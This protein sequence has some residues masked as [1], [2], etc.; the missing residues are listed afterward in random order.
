MMRTETLPLLDVLDVLLGRKV[1]PTLHEDNETALGVIKTGKTHTMR[2]LWRTHEVDIAWLNDLH[3]AGVFTAQKC[4]SGDMRADMFTKAFTEPPRW[5][6]ACKLIG[7]WF[8]G[9]DGSLVIGA[10]TPE[11][12]VVATPAAQRDPEGIEAE[13]EYLSNA[14]REEFP[15]GEPIHVLTHDDGYEGHE[16]DWKEKAIRAASQ[17]QSCQK[18]KRN[19]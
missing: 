15:L 5:H 2:H 4:P 1:I 13:T 11:D 8:P 10:D 19:P 18:S 14:E 12:E 16:L 9:H 17:P 6:R 3:K 7:H